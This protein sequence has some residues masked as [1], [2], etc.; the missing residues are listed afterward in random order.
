LAKLVWNILGGLFV[1]LGALG[2]ILPLLPTTPFMLLAAFCFARGSEKFHSWL[3]NHQTFGPLINN[4]NE[5][6]VVSIGA[7][8]SAI[9]FMLLAVGISMY[10]SVPPYVLWAQIGVLSLVALF[11]LT[12]PSKS[13][14]Q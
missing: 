3:I 6:G 1:L 14:N 7:K 13:K 2:V 9:I 11:L 10:V 12:R 4:W 5:H 8:A